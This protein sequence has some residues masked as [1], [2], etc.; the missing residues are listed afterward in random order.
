AVRDLARHELAAAPRR[1]VIEQDAAAA[2]H[3]IALAVIHSDEMA[4]H[5]RDPIRAAWIE[6]RRLALRRFLDFPEHLAAAGLI[7]ANAFRI[8]QPNRLQ[9]ACHADARKLA[10]QH[11]LFQLV[12]TKLM[13]ARL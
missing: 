7:E 5:F 9:N 4:V 6:R 12:G 1:F 13:A 2:I 8:E 11:G 10:G 3:A